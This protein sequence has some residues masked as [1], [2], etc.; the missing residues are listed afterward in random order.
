MFRSKKANEQ[1][2]SS[3]KMHR[4][5]SRPGVVGWQDG[6]L[7]TEQGPTPCSSDHKAEL[8]NAF[9]WLP[10]LGH[11]LGLPSTVPLPHDCVII[12]VIIRIHVV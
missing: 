5:M 4:L 8:C 12:W 6:T 11:L 7:V 1:R 3:V 2:L 9:Q 10:A